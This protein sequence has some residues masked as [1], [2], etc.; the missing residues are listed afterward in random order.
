MAEETP[1]IQTATPLPPDPSLTPTTQPQPA[2]P[3][4]ETFGGGFR[5]GA[6]GERYVVDAQGN[7][8]NARTTAPSGKGAFG[9]ILA[10]MVMGALAGAH[11][12]RPGGIPSHELGGG[13][14][15]GAEGAADYLQKRDERARG[16]AQQ[17]F[18]NRQS[19]TE[20]KNKDLM[21]QAQLHIS[22]LNEL[23][24]AHELG[25]AERDDPLRHQAL[26]TAVTLGQLN[27]ESETKNLGLINERS[28][29]D[30]QDVPKA[31]IDKFNRHEVKLLTLP[32]GSVKVW[33]RTFDAR[34]TPNPA[35]FEIRDLVGI[36]PK[37]GKPEWKTVGHV[38]AGA[39]TAAQQEAEVDKERTQLLDSG[40]KNAQIAKE[41]AQTEEALAGAAQKWSVAKMNDMM[42]G[43]PG[44]EGG[45]AANGL[46]DAAYNIQVDPTKVASMKNNAREI[47]MSRLLQRHP[48]FNMGAYKQAWDQKKEFTSGKI[49]QNLSNF[50]TAVEHLDQ[51]S[52]VYDAWQGNDL[53]AM[54]RLIREMGYETGDTPQASW[55]IIV[56]ALTGELERAY[57]GV[58]ATQE[59][60]KTLREGFEKGLTDKGSKAAISTAMSTLKSRENSLR[61]QFSNAMPSWFPAEKRTPEA[62]GINLLSPQAREIMGKWGK[63]APP[64]VPDNVKKALESVGPGVHKLSDGSTWT[65]NT[66]GSIT[67]E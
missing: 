42:L 32:D 61:N 36:D 12:A 16:Q 14:G 8:T 56:P 58:G 66:D 20:A 9:S 21:Y 40:L 37:T 3:P 57:T 15:Q 1:D 43:A 10:G 64:P 49:G 26:T 31:D 47:F 11:S 19:A 39:G 50:S 51:L 4:K 65:K 59:G 18:T 2:P 44:T 62:Q 29:K 54:N 13:A 38:K 45:D 24:L 46:L 5:R 41:K 63:N 17:D 53:P 33:D 52:R 22:N 6:A 34:T 27:L 25:E 23:K 60:V 28:Y 48:D 35:D 55:N 67:K 30:Y 7:M